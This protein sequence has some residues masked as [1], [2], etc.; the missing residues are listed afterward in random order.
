[1]RLFNTTRQF[2]IPAIAFH[3][4]MAVLLTGL[5]ASGLWMTGLTY[6]DAWYNRAPDL[7]RAFG[8]VV[9]GLWLLR[10]V[11]RWINPRPA[12]EPGTSRFEQRVAGAVHALMYVLIAAIVVTGYGLSTVDGRSVDVFGWFSVPSLIRAGDG[13]EDTL[14]D[15]HYWLAMTLVGL[16]GLHVL[17]ALKHHFVQ[18]DRT[19]LRIFGVR[20]P[21][22][23]P[24]RSSSDSL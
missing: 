9:A 1:M 20:G 6:Y 4:V 23:G 16:V 2:G 21:G 22:H 13:I 18:R 8:V 15:L 10:L 24:P 3:W 7:H 14:G 5:F 11:W 12:P 17:G 19:L